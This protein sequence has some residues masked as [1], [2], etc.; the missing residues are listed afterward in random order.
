MKKEKDGTYSYTI[1]R[2]LNS[3][4]IIFN[5]GDASDSQQYPEGQGL[6]VVPDKNYTVE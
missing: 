1:E 6:E 4:Y 3:P 5:D 2:D